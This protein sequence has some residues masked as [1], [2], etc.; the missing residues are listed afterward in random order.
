MTTHFWSRLLFPVLLGV[1]PPFTLSVQSL[2][3]CSGVILFLK[4]LT[5]LPRPSPLRV[6]I[7]LLD[8]LHQQVALKSPIINTHTQSSMAPVPFPLY[9][10]YSSSQK[11]LSKALLVTLL[12]FLLPSSFFNCRT[13]GFPSP[14]EIALVEQA[15]TSWGQIQKTSVFIF[16]VF[17]QSWDTPFSKLLSD[18]LVLLLRRLNAEE[19]MLL[20]CGVGEDS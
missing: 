10:L 19:L 9:L 3:L 1:R 14:T 6:A 18:T 17:L 12:P 11:Y 8:H 20:K 13:I 7:A 15:K 4:D 2:F 16:R 5:A